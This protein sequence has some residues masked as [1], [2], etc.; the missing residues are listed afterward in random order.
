MRASCSVAV[1]YKIEAVLTSAQHHDS[2]SA[3]TAD[4]QKPDVYVWALSVHA[5]PQAAP[6]ICREHE[7]PPQTCVL[8]PARTWDRFTIDVSAERAALDLSEPRDLVVPVAVKVRFGCARLGSL[9]SKL[10]CNLNFGVGTLAH[11][12]TSWE[13]VVLMHQQRSWLDVQGKE[14][15]RVRCKA[16]LE[17]RYE[18]FGTRSCMGVCSNTQSRQSGCIPLL[19]LPQRQNSAGKATWAEIAAGDVHSFRFCSDDLAALAANKRLHDMPP[20]Q[21]KLLHISY[22][23]VV[24]AKPM[25]GC[26]NASRVRVQIAVTNAPAL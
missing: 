2:A 21:S 11:G 8:V 9:H 5:Q 22:A 18:T 13:F 15:T 4:T 1:V 26:A 10:R 19:D 12:H 7:V 14:N 17:L 3:P 24:Q 6:S 20:V 23:V 16:S 25:S